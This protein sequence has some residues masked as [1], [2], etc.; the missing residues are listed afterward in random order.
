MSTPSV[1]SLLIASSQVE[2]MKDWYRRCF[3][4]EET[5]MGAFVFG[6]CQVFIE[7]HSEVS[8]PAREP[9]RIILNLDVDDCRAV[10]ARLRAQDV[11]WER[12]VEEMP[13]G[14]IGTVRDPDGNLV[15][16]IEWGADPEEGHGR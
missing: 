2:R 16:I 8:G 12:E 6:P 5:D 14:L 13:F 9:A 4:A 11:E 15:Q 1:G 10:E 7:G 3:G